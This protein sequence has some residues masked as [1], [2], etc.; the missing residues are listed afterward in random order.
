MDCPTISCQS[1]WITQMLIKWITQCEDSKLM[2]NLLCY[3][4]RTAL[5]TLVHEYVTWQQQPVK[6]CQTVRR[7]TGL[8]K[9]LIGVCKDVLPHTILILTPWAGDTKHGWIHVFMLFMPNNALDQA[10][11]FQFG[12]ILVSNCKL[13]ASVFCHQECHSP[14]AVALLLQGCVFRIV[15]LQ[16][17]FCLSGI[18]NA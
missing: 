2:N 14:A 9:G 8:C 13:Q 5:K 17:T 12:P 1:T 7:G 11:F 6:A 10:T 4:N 16:T 18:C 15:F 3:W